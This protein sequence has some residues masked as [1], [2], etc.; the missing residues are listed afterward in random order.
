VGVLA[1]GTVTRFTK[2]TAGLM[3]PSLLKKHM[4]KKSSGGRI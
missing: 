4:F 1:R 2:E 3:D